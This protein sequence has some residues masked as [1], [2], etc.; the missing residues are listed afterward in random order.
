MSRIPRRL[1]R[2]VTLRARGR[3]E[4]CGLSQAGQEATFHIDHVVPSAKRGRTALD[5]LALA[6]VSC[7][8]RKEARQ[9]ALDPETGRQVKLFNPRR[10]RWQD[11]FR[12]NGVQLIGLTATGRATIS[13]LRM[14]RSLILAI[15][16][17]E[18]KHGRHPQ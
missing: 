15:R 1:R 11:H 13:A 3:C 14:N 8:L 5:N 18:M 16:N 2:L 6:C 10:Q 12:W 4:Y 9:S 7:S 17:E